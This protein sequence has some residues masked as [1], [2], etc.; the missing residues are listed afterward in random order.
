MIK[1][2]GKV[3]QRSNFKALLYFHIVIRDL[4]TMKGGITLVL[5][6]LASITIGDVYALKCY[7][8]DGE[9][10][11]EFLDNVC[12]GEDDLGKLVEC[13]GVCQKMIQPKTGEVFLTKD[14][15]LACMALTVN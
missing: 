12:Q 10:R 7:E 2:Q 1:A 3:K 5:F 6:L 9:S 13:P 11:N 8:C 4:V 14:S 15:G